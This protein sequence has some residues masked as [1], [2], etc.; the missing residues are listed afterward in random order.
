M[1]ARA[2]P[3]LQGLDPPAGAA[4][5]LLQLVPA[6]RGRGEGPVPGHPDRGGVLHAEPAGA[7]GDVPA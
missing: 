4:G 6:G 3:V 1:G 5:E 7:E 2:E